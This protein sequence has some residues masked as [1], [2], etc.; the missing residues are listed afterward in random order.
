MFKP[1]EYLHWIKTAPEIT[2]NLTGSGFSS[3]EL[4][5]ELNIPSSEIPLGGENW[6]GYKPLKGWLAEQYG[7]DHDCIAVTPGASLA[8]YAAIVATTEIVDE[9]G[10]EIP[11][12]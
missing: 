7:I 2:V 4:L 11:C 3:P 10:I 6:Y 1:I 5:S 9:I 8:N 12:Y